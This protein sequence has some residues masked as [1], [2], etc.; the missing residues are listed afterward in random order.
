MSG[1]AS[2]TEI[3]GLMKEVDLFAHNLEKKGEKYNV[4][5]KKELEN[6]RTASIQ[7]NN[8]MIIVFVIVTLIVLAGTI[9]VAFMAKNKIVNPLL[10][11]TKATGIISQG[12]LNYQVNIKTGDEIELLSNEFNNMTQGLKVKTEEAKKLSAMLENSNKQ[13]ERNIIQLYTLYNISKSLSTESEM[14]KLLNQ[15]VEEVSHALKVHRINIMLINE[16]RT[17]MSIVAG[18]EMPHQ[19]KEMRVK[20]TEGIYGLVSQTGQAEVFNDLKTNPRF[21]AVTG[22]DDDASSLIC[23]GSAPSP[24][25]SANSISPHRYQNTIKIAERF[26]IRTKLIENCECS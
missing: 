25:I 9:W 16:D 5:I 3:S 23:A 21:K 2:N 6:Q 14:D 12:N 17:E 8:L 18:S 11:F 13:L 15:V 24:F 4:L 22:L 7:H 19:G 20:L 1:Q 26:F 10:E